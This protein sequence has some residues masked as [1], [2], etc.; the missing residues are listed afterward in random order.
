MEMAMNIFG[1]VVLV[2]VIVVAVVISKMSMKATRQGTTFNGQAPSDHP[3]RQLAAHLGLQYQSIPKPTGPEWKDLY[4]WDAH[5]LEGQYGGVPLLGVFE[6]YTKPV[7]G[8]YEWYSNN[9]VTFRT[10]KT[11]SFRIETRK[12]NQGSTPTGVP[13]FDAKFSFSGDTSMVSPA[14]L[15][16]FASLGWVNLRMQNGELV[17]IDD[18]MKELRAQSSNPIAASA[19][20]MNAVHPIWG[21]SASNP[22]YDLARA[23]WFFDVLADIAR[24]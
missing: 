11:G 6:M 10:A 4:Q 19:A 22:N 18:Y 2:V 16:A 3:L 1:A 15:E 13:S 7:T 14:H 5:R 21:Q 23:K 12:A 8:G 20:L 9:R 24:G 17:F